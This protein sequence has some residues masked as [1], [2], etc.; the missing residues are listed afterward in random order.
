MVVEKCFLVEESFVDCRLDKY[1]SEH[2]QE[3]SR[4]QIQAWIKAGSIL[5]NGKVQQSKYKCQMGDVIHLQVTI[6][7][8]VADQ[9]EV[10]ALDIVYEDDA[11]LVLNKPVGLV[12]HPG[13]GQVSGTLLNALLHHVPDAMQLP[14]AGIVHRLDKDTSGIMVVAKTALSY[15]HLI[16]QLSE[17]SMEKHYEAVVVGHMISGGTID[18]PMDRHPKYRTKMSVAPVG[19]GKPAITHYRVVARFAQ[20]THVSL[21][22]ETGRTHQIRV[23]MQY[24]NYPLVG[25]RVY[26]TRRMPAGVPAELAKVILQFPRQAL[27][28]KRIAFLHPVTGEKVTFEVA[29]PADMEQLLTTLHQ[30]SPL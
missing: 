30:H 5:I 23:H 12:V 27:H 9:P 22:I 8:A 29:L 3:F 10:M 1:L 14:R 17:R 6:A 20:F 4:S 18:V 2:L 26:G 19:L 16:A 7:P 11:I 24:K 13:A 21:K 28:A 25:D 15:Q